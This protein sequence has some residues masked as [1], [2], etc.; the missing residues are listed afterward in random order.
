[1]ITLGKISTE[2]MNAKTNPITESVFPQVGQ[3]L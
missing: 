1:M 3:P 2:T